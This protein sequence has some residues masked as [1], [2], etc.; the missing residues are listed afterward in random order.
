MQK[1]DFIW[2]TRNTKIDNVCDIF[3]DCNR[4]PVILKLFRKSHLPKLKTIFADHNVEVYEDKQENCYME[5]IDLTISGF[6]E[7]AMQYNSD[8]IYKGNRPYYIPVDRNILANN[9]WHKSAQQL[10]ALSPQKKLDI[11]FALEPDSYAGEKKHFS[12]L[13]KQF[14]KLNALLDLP[15]PQAFW[16]REQRKIRLIATE[17]ATIPD[18]KEKLEN[19]AELDRLTQQKL[20]KHTAAVTAHYS[21]IQTP[22]LF[23]VSQK[24]MR[25]L[26]GK[27]WQKTDAINI[28]KDIYIGKPWL[29][30]QSGVRCL[31]LAWHETNHVA[32]SFGDYSQFALMEDIM[33]PRLQYTGDVNDSYIMYPQEKI[34]YALEKQFI[35][36]CV[37]RTGIKKLGN[38]FSPA[39]EFDVA[40]QYLTRS[41]Q[42]KY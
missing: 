21:G 20:L 37:S 10:S 14:D 19:F 3:E 4:E 32:M 5:V 2:L 7:I 30:M 35:E 11:L 1:R 15:I 18:I 6:C 28:E 23:L 40:A 33:S 24:E 27:S 9:F 36:E 13:D 34:N 16:E 25:Q 26:A 8:L 31:A 42:K 41:L 39:T 38:T 12:V 17:I 22:K 29:K